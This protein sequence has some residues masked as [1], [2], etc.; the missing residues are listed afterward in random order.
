MESSRIISHPLP[1]LP[2][3]DSENLNASGFQHAPAA[4]NISANVESFCLSHELEYHVCCWGYIGQFF[5]K[6]LLGVFFA[7]IAMSYLHLPDAIG[8][9]LIQ[10]SCVSGAQLSNYATFLVD[11]T[12]APLSI[13]MTAISTATTVF[14]IRALTLCVKLKHIAVHIVSEFGEIVFPNFHG[15]RGEHASDF[16]DD[17]EMAFLVFGKDDE[18][19]K[20][21]AF[22]LVFRKEAKVWFQDLDVGKQGN[23]EALKRSFLLRYRAD[24]NDP[25]EIWRKRSQL[26]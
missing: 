24:N 23:W 13:V 16:L 19:I 11:P 7:T 1:F 8:M 15:R 26:Q 22:P 21:R 9:G 17:L 12:M 18:E 10:V 6:P 2:C 3:E 14:V 20:L 4:S 5:L 25:E